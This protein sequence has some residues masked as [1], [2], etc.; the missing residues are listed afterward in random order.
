MNDLLGDEI[1]VAPKRQQSSESLADL[2]QLIVDADCMVS[3]IDTYGGQSYFIEVQDY[4]CKE[5]CTSGVTLLEAAKQM[6]G[7]L[8]KVKVLRWYPD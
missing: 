6:V 3:C 8:Y 7:L 2:L 1:P 4:E 5:Y